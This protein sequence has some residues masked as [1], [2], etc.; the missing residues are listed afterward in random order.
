M[1]HKYVFTLKFLG[2]N[3]GGGMADPD[4]VNPEQ[5]SDPSDPSQPGDPDINPTPGV[6]PGKPVVDSVINFNVTIEDW[7]DGGASDVTIQN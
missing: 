7:Q 3:S 6:E 5:P 2:P 1:G 4:P